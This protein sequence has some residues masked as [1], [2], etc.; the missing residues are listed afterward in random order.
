MNRIDLTH[1]IQEK[2]PVFPGTE[3]P[4]IINACTMEKDHFREKKL[5]MYSHTGTHMDAPAHMLETGKC[6]DEF[7][8]DHFMGPALVIDVTMYSGDI[9]KGYI[10]S[11]EEALKTV[12]FV[13]LKTGWSKKWGQDDYFEGFPALSKEA[14]SY[15]SQ[16]KLKG[17]GVDAISVDLMTSTSFDVHHTLLSQNMVMIENLCHL[18]LID[19]KVMFYALPLQIQDA[20]GSPVRAFCEKL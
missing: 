1:V 8:V 10:E 19:D 18:D 3:P 20:D 5:T 13:L 16:F 6:L 11:F 9:P 7:P 12:D 15:L 2:M 17:L 4:E 14:A